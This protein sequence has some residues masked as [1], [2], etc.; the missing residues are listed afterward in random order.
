MS[1]LPD[2]LRYANTH[3]WARLEDGGLVRVGI[4]DFAQQQLGDVV[5]IEPPK[6]GRKVAK[7][8]SC[9]IVESVKAASD[10]YSPV[11][12]AIV[13]ANTALCDTP[14]QLN[15]DSYAHWLFT[16]Q[17][18]NPAELDALLDAAGYAAATQAD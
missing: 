16:V 2:D 18:D 11:S 7:G 6:P 15:A 14:E 12:G 17:A 1:K 4:S 8:E 5:F 10:I 3:E 9:A 13:E